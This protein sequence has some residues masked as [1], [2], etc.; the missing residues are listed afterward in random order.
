[1]GLSRPRERTAV[2]CVGYSGGDGMRDSVARNAPEEVQ[3]TWQM[4]GQC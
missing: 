3:F 4:R 1:M 2:G